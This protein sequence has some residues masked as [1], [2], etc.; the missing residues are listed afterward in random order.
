MS[1]SK[2]IE[3]INQIKTTNMTKDGYYCDSFDRF[4]DHLCQLLFSFL[5]IEEK[6]RFECVWKQWQRLVFNKQQKLIINKSIAGKAFETILKKLVFINQIQFKWISIIGQMI[7]LIAKHC[8]DLK[9]IS[10]INCSF[11][12]LI[13]K[14]IQEFGEKFG[15]SFESIDWSENPKVNSKFIK[16]LLNLTSKMFDSF[17]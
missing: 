2:Q 3:D 7:E 6:F 8:N 16:T 15:Q 1:L 12:A 11:G 4:G 9:K 10:K 13:D 5:S 14:Q 17:V